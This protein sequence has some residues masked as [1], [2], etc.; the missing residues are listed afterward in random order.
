MRCRLK[1]SE[2]DQDDCKQALDLDGVLVQSDCFRWLVRLLGV[3][4]VTA[5]DGRNFAV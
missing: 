1:S 2:G 5:L 4:M 3:C